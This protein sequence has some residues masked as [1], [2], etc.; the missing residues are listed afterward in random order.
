MKAVAKV[1]RCVTEG[2]IGGLELESREAGESVA[3][4]S[5]MVKPVKVSYAWE[6]PQ[7]GTWCEGTGVAAKA[8]RAQVEGTRGVPCTGSPAQRWLPGM[9]LGTMRGS[10][11]SVGLRP[12]LPRRGS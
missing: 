5:E 7:T 4:P 2:E 1:Q 3:E 11:W 8:D 9:A 12:R 6:K 10:W